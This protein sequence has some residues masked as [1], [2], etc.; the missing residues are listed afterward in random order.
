MSKKTELATQQG[1]A[2]AERSQ[3][4]RDYRMEGEDSSDAVIP[5]IILHQGDISEKY[6][7]QHPK[8]TLLHSI[9]TE[10]VEA[11]RFTPVGI[12][13]KEWMKFGDKFGEKMAYKTRNKA[14]VPADD[15]E[16]HGDEP[17]AASLFYNFVV[18][19]DGTDEPVCLSLKGSSKMQRS[20]AMSLNQMEKVRSGRGMAPGFYELEV[21]DRENDKGKWKDLKIRP[22]GNPPEKLTKKAYEC[23]QALH[24]KTVA[25]HDDGAPDA[26]GGYDPEKDE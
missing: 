24:V 10:P 22:V 13:W 11:R 4:A 5:R 16:W 2:L 19:F 14:E 25:A 6:Y 15:L 8:G 26:A 3:F 21:V 23:W 20:A 7:G 17:P 9:T 12:A 18:M 1:G